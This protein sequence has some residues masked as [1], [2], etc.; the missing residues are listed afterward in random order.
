[1]NTFSKRVRVGEALTLACPPRKELRAPGWLR[2][3]AP[4]ARGSAPRRLDPVR[5]RLG[6][7]VPL[8][9]GE[10]EQAQVVRPWPRYRRSVR[11]STIPRLPLLLIL[12]LGVVAAAVVLGSP[13]AAVI[14]IVASVSASLITL[15][16]EPRPRVELRRINS[17]DLFAVSR[18]H[19]ELLRI[20][21]RD[22]EPAQAE[23]EAPA[24]PDSSAINLHQVGL[25]RP[26]DIDALV[27]S[28][29]DL[30]RMRAH[31]S[32]ASLRAFLRR[33]PPDAQQ[34]EEFDEQ[35]RD[36]ASQLR[37][38][39][40]EVD[41]YLDQ[42]ARR[43]ELQVELLNPARIDA[44]EARV[45]LFFPEGFAP[46]GRATPP[47]APSEPE[48][49]IGPPL[50]PT[51]LSGLR[52][53]QPLPPI[54][55]VPA[56]DLDR[57]ALADTFDPTSPSYERLPDGGLA[58]GYRPQT[59]RHHK[60]SSA[61]QPIKLDCLLDGVFEIEWRVHASN[62]LRPRAGSMKVEVRPESKGDPI[63]CLPDLRE[64]L[65]LDPGEFG[66]EPELRSA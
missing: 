22:E 54:A 40:D 55:T 12:L 58:I 16:P 39:L 56:T 31:K 21:R 8:Q 10:A 32:P 49:P 61:G 37:Q 43:V 63:Q 46:E 60:R 28:Q 62:L 45:E 1:V 48:I 59:I 57:L 9:I 52:R 19:A 65:G 36:Y 33:L 18:A 24:E 17:P 4:S 50:W 11:F 44:E 34:L 15:P 29:L 13:A 30:L 35:L 26:L 23:D 42:S 5:H 53:P 14:G 47:E 25:R 6:C 2:S 38:W 7:E 27:K 20:V 41:P 66:D 3:R 51:A 64:V